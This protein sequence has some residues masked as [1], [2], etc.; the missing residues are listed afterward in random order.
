[1]QNISSEQVNGSC[2]V[3][4]VGTGLSLSISN[5]HSEVEPLSFIVA[6]PDSYSA[7]WYDH[8]TPSVSKADLGQSPSSTDVRPILSLPTSGQSLL[9][10]HQTGQVNRRKAVISLYCYHIIMTLDKIQALWGCSD[11]YLLSSQ[12]GPTLNVWSDSYGKK[13]CRVLYPSNVSA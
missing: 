4:G 7:P 6:A 8:V 12:T 9:V 11:P 13:L 3:A 1:M 5:K 10:C 2:F